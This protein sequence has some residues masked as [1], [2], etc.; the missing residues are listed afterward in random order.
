MTD[1]QHT[2]EVR[3][4]EANG[5]NGGHDSQSLRHPVTAAEHEVEHLRAVADEGESGATPAILTGRV[6]AIVL[7]IVV[8]IIGLSLFAAHIVTRD[9]GSSEPAAVPWA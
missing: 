8:I 2:H 1:E 3:P 7:P 5:G 4:V 6:M 9:D